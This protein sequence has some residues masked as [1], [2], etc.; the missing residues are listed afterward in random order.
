MI[1]ALP[2]ST[3]SLECS[4]NDRNGRTLDTSSSLEWRKSNADNEQKFEVVVQDSQLDIDDLQRSHNAKYYCALNDSVHSDFVELRV[5]KPKPF[6]Y[7]LNQNKT[8]AT[9]SKDELTTVVSTME[10]GTATS[11][12]ETTVTTEITTT[13]TKKTI[14]PHSSRFVYKEKTKSNYFN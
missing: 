3:L 8:D 2:G 14:K 10:D 1:R 13:T 9:T 7:L 12:D 6:E 4:L 11:E 5:G